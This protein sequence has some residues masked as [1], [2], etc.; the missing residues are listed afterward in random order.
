MG[1]LNVS[2]VRGRRG[3]S[4]GELGGESSSRLTTLL[5]AGPASAP[6]PSLE[7]SA[8]F[9]AWSAAGSNAGASPSPWLLTDDPQPMA[10][11]SS[12]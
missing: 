2:V 4:P 6:P 10:M 5:F 1:V 12:R 11:S 7:P 3:P 8:A 9:T